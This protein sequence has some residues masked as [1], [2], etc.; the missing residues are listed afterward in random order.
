LGLGFAAPPIE[1]S[2]IVAHNLTGLTDTNG[3]TPDWV[4]V[5]NVS[6]A[7]VS[8]TNL[9]LAHQIGDNARYHFPARP[10]APGE[11]FVVFCDN[12]PDQGTNHAPIRLSRSGETIMLTSL[13][14]NNSRTLVDWVSFGPQQPDVAWARLGAGGEFRSNPPTP[15]AENVAASWLGWV[16]TNGG[17]PEFVF[18]FPTSRNTTYTVEHTP[19]IEPG[20]TWTTWQII[21]G[22]GIEKVIRQPLAGRGFFRVRRSP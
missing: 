6:S 12:N 9:S 10:L 5:R 20:S 16:Q 17:S 22:D 7:P 11:H 19:G 14:T 2:E 3:G 1:I 4:E 18:A 21:P 15:A 13:T 8:L